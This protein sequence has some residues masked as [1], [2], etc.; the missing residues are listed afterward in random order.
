MNEILLQN[1]ACYTKDSV[2][3]DPF[4]LKNGRIGEDKGIQNRHQCLYEN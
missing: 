3:P 2:I 1:K 4:P